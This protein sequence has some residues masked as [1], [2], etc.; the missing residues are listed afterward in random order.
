VVLLFCPLVFFYA[1][2]SVFLFDS[3]VKN[4]DA[5]ALGE[6]VQGMKPRIYPRNPLSLLRRKVN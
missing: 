1:A 3:L 6:P 2:L 4:F 5:Y